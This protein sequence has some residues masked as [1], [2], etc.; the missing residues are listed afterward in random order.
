MKLGDA[1]MDKRILKTRKSLYDALLHLMG[2]RAFES[3]K[4]SEIC[5]RAMTNR[6]TFYDHFE[7]KYSLLNSLLLDLKESLKNELLK[8]EQISSSKEYYMECI[9]LLL[10]HID[11]NKKIYLPLMLN[12]K[13]GIAMDMVYSTLLEDIT[14]RMEKE[15]QLKVIQIPA[16]FI[17]TFYVGAIFQVGMKWI[18]STNYYSKEDILKF[19]DIL[20]SEN[21]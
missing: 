14:E 3:I 15:P 13:N 8:N 7:D 9:R 2:E 17:T 6:S 20:L 18:Q 21:L 12:N 4:V 11:E 10:D 1:F 16:D 5:E 19:L